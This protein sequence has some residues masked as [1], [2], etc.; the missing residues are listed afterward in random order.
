MDQAHG[1]SETHHHWRFDRS[2]AQIHFLALAMHQRRKASAMGAV[3]PRVERS[4]PHRPV[5]LA[6]AHCQQRI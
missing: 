2:E 4:D 6:A 3:S 5:N 1:Y